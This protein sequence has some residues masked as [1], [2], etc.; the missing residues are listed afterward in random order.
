MPVLRLFEVQ[1]TPAAW[2]KAALSRW[3]VTLGVAAGA[4]ALLYIGYWFALA[5]ALHKGYDTLRADQ[6]RNLVSLVAGKVGTHGFP[7]RV[8]LTLD[9]VNLKKSGTPDFFYEAPGLSI[10]LSPFS[11][12]RGRLE[13]IASPQ[14]LA[15]HDAG[16]GITLKA[17]S[18][19]VMGALA[20][21]GIGGAL[22]AA[23]LDV[24]GLALTV[25]EAA[26]STHDDYAAKR[27]AV[28]LHPGAFAE[29][30]EPQ[31]DLRFALH[32]SDITLPQRFSDILGPTAARAEIDALLAG[33]KGGPFRLDA[34]ARE[35]PRALRTF[36]EGD[37]RLEI[38]HLAVEWGKLDVV[39]HGALKLDA[40]HRPEGTLTVEAAGYRAVMNGFVR[41]GI[42][43]R[44]EADT[45]GATLDLLA[46]L[47]RDPKGRVPVVLI[48]QKGKLFVG[49]IQAATL[50]PLF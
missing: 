10:S 23:E 28:A 44:Q 6:A 3:P 1:L 22:E 49:P 43:A 20:L 32:G 47:R 13:T 2:G 16:S 50:T 25:D 26:S 31:K 36:F 19:T 30:G 17:T 38:T 24:D 35:G 29:N 48:F 27:L 46:A 33:G 18:Q 45:I 37:G 39:A 9:A 7:G 14:R 21:S 40:L 11:P 4:L 41:R 8:T 34:L 42:L 12:T 5:G 15:F